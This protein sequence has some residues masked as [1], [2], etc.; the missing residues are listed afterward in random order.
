MFM[1]QIEFVKKISDNYKNSGTCTN[2]PIE[3]LSFL[4]LPCSK[5][6]GT[7]LSTHFQKYQNCCK[8]R[9]NAYK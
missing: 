3:E 2:H 8:E 1:N 6:T 9:V 4:I 7:Y 5:H